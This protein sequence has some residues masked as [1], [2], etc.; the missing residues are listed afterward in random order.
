MWLLS[1]LSGLIHILPL[2]DMIKSFVF[3]LFFEPFLIEKC[4][5]FWKFW[6]WNNPFTIY[7]YTIVFMQFPENRWSRRVL[8]NKIESWFYKHRFS[9]RLVSNQI[10]N[11][12]HLD[13]F[14]NVFDTRHIN[15]IWCGRNK[16]RSCDETSTF[17]S[18]NQEDNGPKSQ[19]LDS[20]ILD[21]PSSLCNGTVT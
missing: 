9:G 21:E 10:G 11:L 20:L 4:R 8:F 3:R 12:D 16:N 18:S 2:D 6:W 14:S 17:V 13:F 15:K 1:G 19:L 7:D 5:N